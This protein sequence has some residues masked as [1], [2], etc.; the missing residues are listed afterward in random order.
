M[1]LFLLN[2]LLTALYLI[3]VGDTSL[4]SILTGFAIGY[5]VLSIYA[6]AAHKPSYTRKAWD[7]AM[8]LAYFIRLLVVA[9]MQ[10]AWEIITPGYSMKPRIIR[11]SVDGLTMV[12]I[13]TLANLISLTPG[14]LSA[15]VDE[16]GSHLY[17]HCMYAGDRDE[18]VRQLDEL[19]DHML[20]EIF[21][22]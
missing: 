6:V 16:D 5:L 19:K 7:L 22:L 12:Q 4:L 17:V 13:T 9:N 14:T 1:N 8:F 10:V 2:I 3:L 15:D 20:R 11:Y 21:R 18:A